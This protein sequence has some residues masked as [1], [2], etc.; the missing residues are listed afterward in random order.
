MLTIWFNPH[1]QFL[2]YSVFF[3]RRVTFVLI[4]HVQVYDF[5]CLCV[6]ARARASFVLRTINAYVWVTLS[7]TEP[8]VV[9]K[10]W[11]FQVR[12]EEVEGVSRYLGFTAHL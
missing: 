4:S 9:G 6:F 5:V 11:Y 3:V 7:G 12:R 10:V 8:R 2:E 1:L